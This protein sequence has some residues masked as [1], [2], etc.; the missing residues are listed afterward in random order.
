MIVVPI[1]TLASPSTVKV[2]RPIQKTQD[3]VAALFWAYS[4]IDPQPEREE[5]DLLTTLIEGA[6]INLQGLVDVDLPGGYKDAWLK[7]RK[8]VKGCYLLAQGNHRI[9]EYNPTT[10]LYTIGT[11][12]ER[13]KEDRREHVVYIKVREDDRIVVL[14]STPDED[15]QK[16]LED[17]FKMTAVVLERGKGTLRYPDMTKHMVHASLVVVRDVYG[18]GVAW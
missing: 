13:E 4:D 7:F 15:L 1:H 5:L 11:T 2:P 8:L 9:I 14:N 16:R 18:A 12:S 3:V 17:P 10:Q 6:W